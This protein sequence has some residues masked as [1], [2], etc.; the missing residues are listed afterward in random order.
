MLKRFGILTLLG[1]ENVFEHTRSAIAS[2]DAAHG[3]EP[4]L[5]DAAG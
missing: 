3:Q 1:P 4:H 5:A 2:I